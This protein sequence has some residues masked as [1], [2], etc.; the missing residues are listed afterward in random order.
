VAA[1]SLSDSPARK[2]LEQQLTAVL[3]AG[4][5]TVARDYLCSKLALIGSGQSVPALAAWLDDAPGDTAARDALEALPPPLA[6]QALCRRLPRLKG[7]AKVGAVNSLGHLRDAAGAGPLSE[8]LKDAEG[9]VA[10]AAAAALGGIGSVQAGEALR[11]FYPKAPEGRL[12]P[13]SPMRC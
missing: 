5:S 10:A 12:G 1:A 2:Q 8:L 6:A 9:E 13:Q 11:D 4:G 7:L 3:Q